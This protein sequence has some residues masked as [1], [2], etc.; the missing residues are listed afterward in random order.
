[1][2]FT[3]VVDKVASLRH[4]AFITDPNDPHHNTIDSGKLVEELH[5][6]VIPDRMRGGRGYMMIQLNDAENI[7]QFQPG[8]VLEVEIR[9]KGGQ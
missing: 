4:R 7:G 3:F 9:R 1:M 6:E 2:I 5:L 8:E